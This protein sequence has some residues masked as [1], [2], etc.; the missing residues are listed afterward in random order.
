MRLKTPRNCVSYRILP[1]NFRAPEETL[2]G[3]DV[4]IILYRKLWTRELQAL[5]EG[6]PLKQWVYDP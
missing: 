6:R 3:S 5:A 2:G 4:S 1:T